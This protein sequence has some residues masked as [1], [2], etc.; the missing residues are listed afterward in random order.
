MEMVKKLHL[1][2]A[3]LAALA[4]VLSTASAHA[5]QNVVRFGS[6][7]G[8]NMVLQRDAPVPVW[9][10]ANP[11]ENVTV[12]LGSQT[13]SAVANTGGKWT[14]TLAKMPAGGSFDLTASGASSTITCKNV[15]FG[16]VWLAS[17]QSNMQFA[18]QWAG[19]LYASEVASSADPDLR[20]AYVPE[21]GSLVPN[22]SVQCNWYVASPTTTPGF[23]AV[24]YFFA[25]ILREKL[26]VPVGIIHSSVGA[27]AVE[28]WTSLDAIAQDPAYL[29]EA[30]KSLADMAAQPAA[31]SAFVIDVQKWQQKYGALDGANT[32][33]AQ[34]WAKPEFDDSDWTVV[35]IP[36]NL[37]GYGLKAGGVLWLRKTFD[38][39][40]SA[41]AKDFSLSLNWS[42]QIAVTVYV[43]G[44]A[45]P[46]PDPAHRYYHRDLRVQVPKSIIHEGANTVA[47]R[48]FGLTSK[49]YDWVTT[50]MMGIPVA[51]PKLLDNKWKKKVEKAFPDLPAD[52]LASQP[53]APTAIMRNTLTVFFNGM[54]NPLI[55]Y[56]IKGVIW[57]QGES[58]VSRWQ[59]YRQRLEL[60]IADWRER[61][62]NP[63]MPFYMVQLSAYGQTHKEPFNSTVAALRQAQLQTIR[64]FPATGMAVSIDMGEESIHPLRKKPVG[65]RLALIAL[66]QTYGQTGENSGPLF[67]SAKPEGDKMRVVFDHV[68]GRLRAQGGQLKLFA[69]A[70]EDKVFHWATAVIDGNTVLA[71]SP[72]VPSP[73]AVRYGWDDNPGGVN[74]YN[75]DGLPASPFRSDEWPL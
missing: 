49:A 71:S 60:N 34:S 32:G 63:N 10:R 58:N 37:G 27:T 6:P 31:E 7:F 70:G 1:F 55:P 11:G 8:D 20:I 30:K 13:V 22:D 28:A 36:K 9:G 64:E 47:I 48:L 19:S 35:D 25:R 33:F 24:A 75:G 2:M 68:V 4:C 62:C 66:T 54:I 50:S 15:T 16:E 43:N 3:G 46:E 14:V 57:Y 44:V 73:I 61:W 12:K 51:D 65:E 18:V 56:A 26:N 21:S 45:L 69:V 23:S 38:L 72:D 17:G 42:D 53:V 59:S 39:P 5:S 52:A 41:T 67:V 29:A 40:E 74:L